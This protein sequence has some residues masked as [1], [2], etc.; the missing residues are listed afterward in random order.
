MIKWTCAEV[1]AW[2]ASNSLDREAQILLENDIDGSILVH[3]DKGL[4]SEMGIN[5]IRATVLLRLRDGL[6]KQTD[7]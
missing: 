4:C 7:T 5:A 1:A 6:L 2:L 3:L